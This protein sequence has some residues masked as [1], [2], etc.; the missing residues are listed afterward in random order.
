MAY[1]EVNG[2]PA[3]ADTGHGAVGGPGVFAAGLLGQQ[4]P[5]HSS[6]SSRD[7]IE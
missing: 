4:V 6:R 5:P 1:T 7:V 3:T 2:L